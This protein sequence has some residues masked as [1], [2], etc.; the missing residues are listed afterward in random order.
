MQ[1]Q[2]VIKVLIY[3]VL[4]SI[5]LFQFLTRLTFNPI[6]ILDGGGYRIKK[7]ALPP[8]FS[9]APPPISMSKT[10]S[11]HAKSTPQRPTPLLHDQLE[12]FMFKTSYYK[13]TLYSTVYTVYMTMH[14]IAKLLVCWKNFQYEMAL[15][16]IVS[17]GWRLRKDFLCDT[18]QV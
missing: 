4:H 12:H 15:Q 8:C 16:E 10:S 14:D 5:S 11:Y 13:Y 2:C 17:Q 6:T 3:V 1:L 18:R 9:I 7:I